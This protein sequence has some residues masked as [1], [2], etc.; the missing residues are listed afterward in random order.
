MNTAS[1]N[2]LVNVLKKSTDPLDPKGVRHTYHDT[3]ALVFLGLLARIPY[4]AHIQ[5]WAE[6]H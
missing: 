2:A 4:I 3:L 1:L 6:K 5:R